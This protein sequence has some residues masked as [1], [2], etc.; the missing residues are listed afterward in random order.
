M[1]LEVSRFVI[2]PILWISST[3]LRRRHDGI[4]IIE[5]QPSRSLTVPIT[6]CQCKLFG[7][8]F[9][10][11]PISTAL[12]KKKTE[13][14]LPGHQGHTLGEV[15]VA[16]TGYYE[17]MSTYRRVPIGSKLIS[18]TVLYEPFFL[19]L[20]A[21]SGATMAGVASP[22]STSISAQPPINFCQSLF[23][24]SSWLFLTINLNRSSSIHIV[25]ASEARLFL[26]LE[27]H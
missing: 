19:L 24:K 6:G 9:C 17:T 18:L 8:P 14:N 23:T 11:Q 13:P 27:T 21:G 12:C 25:H 5:I 16:I 7:F 20:F 3:I 15:T 22:P 4:I 2:H 10:N 26:K 1:Q